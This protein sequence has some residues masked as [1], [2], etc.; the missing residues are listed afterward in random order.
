MTVYRSVDEA[1]I[2]PAILCSEF[3]TVSKIQS[4]IND[5]RAVREAETPYA[6]QAGYFWATLQQ[7]EVLFKEQASSS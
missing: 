3:K 2:D 7:L 6:F 5:A 1:R 4:L